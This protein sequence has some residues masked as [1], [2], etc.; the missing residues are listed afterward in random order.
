MGENQRDERRYG[1]LDRWGRK[2]ILF[3]IIYIFINFVLK[4]KKK[5]KGL[6]F[7]Q[8]EKRGEFGSGVPR[9]HS[10]NTIV[11]KAH[12]PTRPG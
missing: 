4:K 9:P 3:Y 6:N 5:K 10:K 7:K 1:K 12:G 11:Y 8:R 2:Y